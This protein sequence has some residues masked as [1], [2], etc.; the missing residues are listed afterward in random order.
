L[1]LNLQ[2]NSS[3]GNSW[4]AP[5]TPN[6]Y[7]IYYIPA[8]ARKENAA[9]QGR[10]VMLPVPYRLGLKDHVHVTILKTKIP[11]TMTKTVF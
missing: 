5:R 6:F 4:K 9:K 1:H 8:E 2:H 7:R 10:A 11:H 3:L